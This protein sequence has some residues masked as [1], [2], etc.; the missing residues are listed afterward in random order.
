MFTKTTNE[1]AGIGL[2]EVRFQPAAESAASAAVATAAHLVVSESMKNQIRSQARLY[3]WG[4]DFLGS[5]K[6]IRRNFET[7]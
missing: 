2:H 1:S 4:L 3:R 7:W 5:Q 6:S